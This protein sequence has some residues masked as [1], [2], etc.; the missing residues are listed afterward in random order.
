ME[1]RREAGRKVRPRG[2]RQ[3]DLTDVTIFA[4]V[5]AAGYRF[6]LNAAQSIFSLV[7]LN[8]AGPVGNGYGTSTPLCV[9]SPIVGP[10]AALSFFAARTTSSAVRIG[11]SETR[12]GFGVAASCMWY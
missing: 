12:D 9:I 10:A 5:E 1:D 3:R 7:M 11:K 8:S 6:Q 2:R 4:A